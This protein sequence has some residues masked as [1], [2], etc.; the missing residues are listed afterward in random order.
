MRYLTLDTTNPKVVEQLIGFEGV[1]DFLLLLGFRSDAMGTKLICEEKPAQ[2]V[3]RNA[4]E[5]LNTYE[6]RLGLGRQKTRND[7]NDGNGVQAELKTDNGTDGS[8]LGT[9]EQIIILGT[10]ENTG[11]DLSQSCTMETLIVTHKHF[12]TSVC[13]SHRS[14]LQSKV[15]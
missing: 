6:T 3:I 5:V 15:Q 10:H 8:D 13:L 9:L 1:F 4:L 7:N 12:S 14:F 11:D 2:Q